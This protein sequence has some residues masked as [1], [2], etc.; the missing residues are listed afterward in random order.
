MKYIIKV[1]FING[2]PETRYVTPY[3]RERV[4]DNVK[5]CSPSL[6]ENIKS[7]SKF[8]TREG[9]ETRAKLVESQVEKSFNAGYLDWTVPCLVKCT[10]IEYK[11]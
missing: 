7:S 3:Y 9:A 6:S 2:Y 1:D 10:V 8:S 5:Y 4:I 11:K